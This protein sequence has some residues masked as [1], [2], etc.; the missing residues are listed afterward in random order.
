MCLVVALSPLLV[1]KVG[2]SHSV[3]VALSPLLVRR[4]GTGHSVFNDGS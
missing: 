1:R 4:V 3:V 2:T